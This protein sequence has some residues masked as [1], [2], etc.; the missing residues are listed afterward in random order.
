LVAIVLARGVHIC[1]RMSGF[2]SPEEFDAWQLAWELK[3][4][5]YAFTAEPRVARDSKFCE[6]IRKSARSA[7][8][9]IAEGFYRFN[10]P[11]FANFVRVARGSLGEVRNQLLHAKAREYLND[12]QFRELSRLCRRAIGASRGLRLYLL[13]LPKNFDPRQAKAELN[14]SGREPKRKLSK[15]GPQEP[16]PMEPEPKGTGTLG[17]GTPGTR[18]PGTR[19]LGTRTL[20]TQEP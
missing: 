19:T 15:A 12:E 1:D 11:D 7:P 10:P 14:R 6:E 8:D 13:S 9:N 20:G 2:N 18:T 4:K 5:V 3:E 16:E 17:T